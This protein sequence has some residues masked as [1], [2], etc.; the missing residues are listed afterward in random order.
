MRP[1]L[2]SLLLLLA[3]ST[4]P[5]DV[6][7]T[8]D[9]SGD[10]GD[11]TGDTGGQAG[12]TVGPDLPSCTP[13][14]GSADRVAISGVVLT[15]DGPEAGYVVYSRNTGTIECAGDGC[16]VGDATVVCGEGVISPGL[17]DPHNHL[18]YNSLPPWQVGPEFE[19]RYDWQGDSRYDDFKEAYNAVKDAYKCEIMQWSEARLVAHGT[20]AAVGS[21]GDGCIARGVRNLDED[22]DASHLEDYDLSYS[23]GNVT[24]S[25]EDGDGDYWR[26]KLDSGSTDAVINHVAEGKDGSVT[27]EVDFMLDLGMT[28]PG[29]VYVHATDATTAQLAQMG[30]SGTGILWSPRSN[31]AL[32]ATTTPVEIAENLGVPWAIGTDWT[33]SGSIGQPQELACAETWLLGKGSPLSDVELWRKVT[34]DAARL[35]GADGVLGVLAPGAAADIAVFDYSR[36]PY[37]AIIGAD[38]RTVRL[39]VVDGEL[40]YGH[41]EY[42]TSLAEDPAWCDT[43][44]ACGESRGYCLKGADSGELGDTLADVEATLTA[45]LAAEAMAS[46]YE[47][48]GEL[49]G[50]YA[51][52]DDREVCDLREPQ[53]GDDDGDGV[54]DT[55]D[56]CVGIYDPAQWDT[57]G[58]GLGD[59]CDICP[60]VPGEACEL[61]TDDRDGDGIANDDDGCPD[62]YDDGTDGD[63]D[64]TPDACDACPEVPNAGGACPATVE[65][66]RTGVFADG[67]T[68]EITDVVVTAVRADAGFFVQ[69]PGATEYGGLYVYEGGPVSVVRGDVVTVQ[70][71]YTEYYEMTELTSPTVT[72]TG[73][74]E[75]PEPLALD[76]CA[77]AGDPEPTENMLVR[78]TDVEVTD[79]NADSDTDTPDYDEFVID[80]CLRV[81][82]FLYEAL[83][84]PPLGLGIDALAGV[85]I[86]SFDNAK[87]APRDDA[88]IVAP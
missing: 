71:Q 63:G 78:F 43:V 45:A 54:A 42:V 48:A 83:D 30:L 16:T 66:L 68:V 69:V 56:V 80:G 65:E 49:Y 74:A 67:A 55:G 72:V 82:D 53:G 28:G 52:V 39:V 7:D 62:T 75:V 35:V 33:P 18:Q 85:M 77:V 79:D 37:R 84:Q 27:A 10:T 41:A 36:T 76:V 50:L 40:V 86:Y 59:S 64:G 3:C 31:L 22:Q 81:D 51:C 58:D 15:P 23:S 24:S 4:A 17:I 29:Q 47:Y 11:D 34:E 26:G 14:S 8:G 44:D 21:S 25:L 20:T 13:V 5:T 46:G 70:G 60:T 6:V 9:D 19:D 12:D 38:E 32:Y 1:S 88:D 73:S 61:D 57:D 2:L 87:L